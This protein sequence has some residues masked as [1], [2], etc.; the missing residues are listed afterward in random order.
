MNSK[1]NFKNESNEIADDI[2]RQVDECKLPL[3][4]EKNFVFGVFAFDLETCNIEN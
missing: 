3:C 2:L 4:Y 1:K